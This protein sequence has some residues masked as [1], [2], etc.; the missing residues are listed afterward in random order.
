MAFTDFAQS[1]ILRI[2]ASKKSSPVLKLIAEFPEASEK[3]KKAR[4]GE[5]N[6]LKPG[7]NV[8]KEILAII[9]NR[10]QSLFGKMA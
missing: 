2:C 9:S 7:L 4:Q 1:V 3:L 5:S 6:I 10:N 8:N